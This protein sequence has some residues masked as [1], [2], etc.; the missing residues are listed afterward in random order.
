MNRR[1]AGETTEAR[2]APRAANLNGTAT[3]RREAEEA[4]VRA[5]PDIATIAEIKD[6]SGE[7]S[8]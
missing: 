7:L 8:T 5:K 3:K 2:R 1:A 6:I 4:K